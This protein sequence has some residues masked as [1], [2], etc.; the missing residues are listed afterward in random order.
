MFGMLIGQSDSSRADHHLQSTKI[1]PSL[2]EDGLY[3]SNEG[4]DSNENYEFNEGYDFDEGY[5]SVGDYHSIWERLD[6][7]YHSSQ[8]DDDP[9][10]YYT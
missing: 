5:Q 9:D 1:Y 4:Y 8:W 3:H 10:E 7:E 6:E 2:D